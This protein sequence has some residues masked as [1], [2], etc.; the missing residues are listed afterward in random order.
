MLISTRDS[1]HYFT[2]HVSAEVLTGRQLDISIIS[3]CKGV[4]TL[5]TQDISAPS[6]WSGQFGTSLVDTSGLVPICLDLHQTFFAT[7]GHTEERFNITH[8]YY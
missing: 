1:F 3:C 6:D 8:Y 7:I 2:V 5:R 4:K